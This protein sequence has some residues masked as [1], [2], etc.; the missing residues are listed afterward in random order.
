[1]LW[2]ANLVVEGQ[3]KGRV[4]VGEVAV[5]RRWVVLVLVIVTAAGCRP[6]TIW[7]GVDKV[8]SAVDAQ[9]A[10]DAVVELASPAYAGRRTGTTG[11][12]QAAAWI[13]SQF[14]AIGLREPPGFKEY[15]ATY[16]APLYVVSSFTGI[17]A[18][19]T[20]GESFLGD[21]GMAMP[22]AGSGSVEADAVLAGFGVQMTG[23]D[24]YAG[25]DVAG[26]VV[27]LLRYSA[28]TRS[29]PE[30]QTY[31][32]AKVGS[33]AAH[34]A[35]GV[36]IL[37]MPSAPNPFDMHGQV[38]SALPDAPV[39]A[40]VSLAGA[41]SLFWAARLS[42][43]DIAAE[44]WAG[45]IV[46]RDLDLKVSFGTTASWNPNATA[47]NVA[48]VLAGT[49]DTRPIMVCSHL[50]HL[51][52][53]RSGVMYPGADDDASGVAVM[54]EMARSMVSLGAVPPVSIWF[55]AFSGE[56]EGLLGSAAFVTAVPELAQSLSAV[57]D[58]DMMRSTSGLGVAIDPSDQA[59]MIAVSGAIQDGASLAI[60]P[61]T[62]G[63]DHETFSRLGVSSCMFSAHGR[64]APW[65][66]ATTDTAEDL[67]AAVLGTAA[68]DVLRVVW[69]LTGSL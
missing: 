69:G 59:I 37:D 62:G 64:E 53:D 54:L 61:W 43:D 17:K 29:V 55:V 4:S 18:T 60:I 48:G 63:S 58:L 3:S 57:L 39:S 44:A 26:K 65:Y 33:A 6:R 24:E 52:T 19:G 22:Y 42:F 1:M 28:P 20:R 5:N 68:R 9:R 56:E 49:D 38:V 23:Y 27:I 51:G 10:H 34:G 21:R 15:L 47:F 8:V 25:L 35:A 16:E 7:P 67:P 31:L 50:D 32:A 66:H 12:A 45:Q 14:K 41:R 36:L 40:L 11:E 13:A 30:S 46:S 2:S